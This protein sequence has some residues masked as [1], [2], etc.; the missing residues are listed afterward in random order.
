MLKIT[1]KDRIFAA[2]A[3]P[4]LLR[5]ADLFLLRGLIR[6]ADGNLPA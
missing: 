2:V 5:A 3:I 6:L 4:L 1:A